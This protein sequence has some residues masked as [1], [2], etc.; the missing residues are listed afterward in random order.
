MFSGVRGRIF[1]N[2]ILILLLVFMIAKAQVNY[3]KGRRTINGVVVLQ[4]STDEKKFYYLPPY[5]R[6]SPAPGGGYEFLA[7]KFVDP[8]GDTNGGLLHFLV[9]FDLPPE[10]VEELQAEL[11]KKVAGAEIMGPV[12]MFEAKGKDKEGASTA[13]RVVSAVLTDTEGGMTRSL[14]SSGHAPL[15]PG[16]KSAVAAIL[17]QQGATLLWDTLDG[18]TSDISIAIHANYEAV[19]EGFN[20]RIHAEVSTIYEHFSRVLNRQ[21][22]YKKRELRDIVDE[23]LR[24][25][26]VNVEVFDRSEGLGIDA[27]SMRRIADLCTDKLVELIFN[28]ETGLTKLPEREQAVEAGQIQRRQERGW[29]AKLFVGTGDQPYVTDNQYVIKRREDISQ[30]VFSINLSARTTVKIPFD[31][32]GNIRG[33]YTAHKDDP[34]M[35]RIVNLAD[36]SFQKREI[37]FTIDRDYLSAFKENINFVTLN[38]R[39]KYPDQPTATRELQFTHQDVSE[40]KIHKFVAYPRLGQEGTEWLDYEYRL[41]WSIYGQETVEEPAGEDEWLKSSDAVINLIPPFDKTDIELEADRGEFEPNNIQSGVVEVRYILLGETKSERMT[42]LRAK[43]TDSFQNFII[44]HDK[45]K[46]PEIRIAWYGKSGLGRKIEDWKPIDSTYLFLEPPKFE[47]K[48][49]KGKK[50]DDTGK[51]KDK[52]K[53]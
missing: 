33:F 20:A 44:Y 26:V 4:D 42:V 27:T 41:S 2:C 45:D 29:L 50:P 12:P 5:P 19:V 21:K 6:L 14:I 40:G 52:D 1:A 47:K 51:V 28:H 22:G 30:S 7:V 25:A 32:S 16:S 10:E 17:N 36:P 38:F 31:T 34:E 49:E 43:D 11:K 3:D 18:Q 23:M 39:K 37:H 48:E 35:F 46:I 15:T 8:E 9:Q 53:G 13:F 24:D